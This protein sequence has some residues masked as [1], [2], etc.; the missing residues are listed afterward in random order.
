[1]ATP[2][3]TPAIIGP[4]NDQFMRLRERKLA[5]AMAS[6]ARGSL[7]VFHAI[8]TCQDARAMIISERSI[9]ANLR[10]PRVWCAL[11]DHSRVLLF[12]AMTWSLVLTPTRA[13]AEPP[14]SRAA[15]EPAATSAAN[16]H[17]SIGV[18]AEQRGDY[19]EA[20]RQYTSALRSISETAGA[21]TRQNTLIDIMRVYGA[22]FQSDNDPKHLHQ[23]LLVLHA[24]EAELSQLHG[25]SWTLPAALANSRESLQRQVSALGPTAGE[26]TN[27]GPSTTPSANESPNPPDPAVAV[28]NDSGPPAAPTSTIQTAIHQDKLQKA[29]TWTTIAGAAVLA[30]TALLVGILADR[31]GSFENG[32]ENTLADGGMFTEDDYR[33]QDKL[34]KTHR[35]HQVALAGSISAAALV[36][37]GLTLIVVGRRQSRHYARALPAPLIGHNAAG[38]VWSTEF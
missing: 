5:R 24:Y 14:S 7:R 31:A 33:N 2:S 11:S 38:V 15:A 18:A 25:P 13:A 21:E 6:T 32:V 23:A 29:G 8:S 9:R 30:P 16:H 34:W 26:K 27:T 3:N 37:T 4:R 12:C 10:R 22:A 19:A 1:M 36:T 17:Y 35:W 28:P 20:G